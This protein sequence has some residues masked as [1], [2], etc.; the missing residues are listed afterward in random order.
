MAQN[1]EKHVTILSKIMV[2]LGIFYLVVMVGAGITGLLVS[3]S[4]IQNSSGEVALLP[5]LLTGLIIIIPI[6]IL[7]IMH[8]VTG[9]AFRE[10][11]NW[12]VIVMWVLAILNLGNIPLGTALGAY[13]IWV[14]IK[15]REA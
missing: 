14:L 6:G 7:G 3:N 8:I 1:M 15:M 12:T 9:R 5:A 11:A 10:G 4:F 13:A 2:W